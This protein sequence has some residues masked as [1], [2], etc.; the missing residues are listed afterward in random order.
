MVELGEMGWPNGMTHPIPAS[1]SIPE[2]MKWWGMM[3]LDEN[4]WDGMA[5]DGID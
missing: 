3:L 5:C 1:N 4:G 2:G